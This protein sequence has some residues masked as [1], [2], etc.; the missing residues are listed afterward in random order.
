[1]LVQACHWLIDELKAEVPIWKKA[2]PAVA[3]AVAA[4][5][6]EQSSAQPEPKAWALTLPPLEQETFTDGE[7]WKS[8]ASGP[9]E[10]LTTGQA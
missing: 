3:A 9:A 4:A 6:T 8:N 7:V 5:V 2:R 1:M 10:R